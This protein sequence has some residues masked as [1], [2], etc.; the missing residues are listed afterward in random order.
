MSDKSKIEWT[1]ATWN[2]LRG[3]SIVSDGCRNCYA[4]HVA[5]RF[6]KPGQP[7]DGLTRQTAKGPRWTGKI[8]LVPEKLSEPLRWRK[9]RRIF[10]NS[11]SDLFH[12][13][14]PFE[15]IAA[16]FAV[17]AAASDHQFQVLTK[18]PHRALQFFRFLA[19]HFDDPE[20]KQITA[21]VRV[22]SHYL[23]Q[24][25]E[26][27]PVAHQLLPMMLDNP[28]FAARAPWPLPNVWLGVSVEDQETANERI[29]LLLETPAAV[30]WLSCEPLLGAIGLDETSAGDALSECVDHYPPDCPACCDLGRIHWVVAGGESGKDARPMHPDWVRSLRDQCQAA[31][32]PFFFKQWGEYVPT[33]D[34]DIEDRLRFEQATVMPDGRVRQWQPDYPKIRAVHSRMA[35]MRRVGKKSAGRL[36]DGIQHDEMPFTVKP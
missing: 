29:P 19:T 13:D 24:Y 32:V 4:M 31:G 26:H 33:A 34:L 28:E 35:S 9:P 7:Y 16:V 18:R 30:R 27:I 5:H 21:P 25:Q 20:G 10:V 14:V 1:E 17:M 36:L 22:L 2:P 11:M 8:M 15:F 23:S 12:E 3:C 6:S